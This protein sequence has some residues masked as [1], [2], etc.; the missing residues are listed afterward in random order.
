MDVNV[1]RIFVEKKEGFDIKAQTLLNELSES[2][3][4]EKLRRVR[5]I[6]RYDVENI[7]L[8]D[9]EK[10]KKTIF[11]DMCVDKVYDEDFH[12]SP[13]E[14]AFAI[15]YLPGQYDQRADFAM[16][17]IN[18]LTLS[19]KSIVK[20]AKL[21]ILEGDIT[22]EQFE[23]IKDYCINLLETREAS[24]KKPDT[25]LDE[26]AQIQ[27]VKTIKGFIGFLYDEMLSLYKNEG[28]A[29]SM[30][31]LLFC[32]DYFKN[33]EN[34][35]PTIT[36]L[37]VLDTY[38]S[39]HCR[40][41]TFLTKIDNLEIEN[42]KYTNI[43]QK[44]YDSY[45]ALR[46]KVYTKDSR[47]MTL[48]D[49]ATIN[50]KD[51]KKEGKLEDLDVSK[52]VNA[53]TIQLEAEVENE[54][55]EYLVSFKNETHNHPTEIEPFGGAAT[56]LGG[57]IRDPLSARAY[58]HQ[59]MRVSG[60]G[61][62]RTPISETL[63]GKLP[64][65]KITTVAAEGYSSYGNQIGLATGLV[66]EIYHEGYI[67]K[68]MEIGAVVG[69]T[70]KKNVCRKEP[71]KGD[72]VILLGG[73]T[74]RDGCGGATGSSKGHNEESI[75]ISSAEV[76]KGNP[77]T[78]RKIQRLF[79]DPSVS[80]L[81]K[82]CNDFGAG[83]VCVAIGEL[84]DG[85][86]I[87]LDKIPKKYQGLDGTELAISES[88]ERMAVVV[89]SKDESKFIELAF[90]ENLEATKVAVVTD[91]NR[92][93][94]RYKD[95]FIVDLDRAFLDT[96]GVSQHTKVLIKQPDS[97]GYF[98]KFEKY[99]EY[100]ISKKIWVECLQDL[101]VCSKKGLV[102]MF[103]ATIGAG[104]VNMPFGGKYQISPED[105]MIAKL[106]VLEGE[107][108][109]GTIMAYG[110]NPYISS[111]SPFHAGVY[112]LVEAVTKVVASGGDFRRIRLSLQEYF[113]KP[114]K[115]I[116]KWGSPFSA[117]L[118][119]SFAQKNLEIP[120]IGGKDSMSGNFKDMA[121]P[122]TI[123]SFALC[124]TDVSKTVYG[125]FKRSGSRVLLLQSKKDKE[126]LIDFEHLKVL[127]SN[128]NDCIKMGKVISARAVG[129]GGLIETISKMSFGNKM[130]FSF[131]D[132]IEGV[133][134][135]AH[136][137]IY[138]LYGSIV[139]EIDQEED[140][141]VLFPSLQPKTI[142]YTIDNKTIVFK[143]LKLDLDDLIDEWLKP[144]EAVFP[145]MAYEPEVDYPSCETIGRGGALVKPA[146]R[147]AKPKVFIPILPGTNCEYDTMRAFEKEGAEAEVFVVNNLSAESLKD[148]ILYMA[149]IIKKSQIIA[150][151]GGFSAGDEPDGAGKFIDTIF[152]NP[153][154]K[155][156][157]ME[158]IKSRDG[159]ILGICNGFQALV[160]LGLL[161][162]GE[163]LEKNENFPVLTFNNLGR[164]VS[165]MVRTK[166]ISDLSPWL[167]NFSVGDIHTIPV[168]H[169]EG[170]FV[171]DND[172]LDELIKNGQIAT[173][174]VDF[175]G[176][177]TNEST[178]NP[179]GSYL[180]IE[181]ITSKCG[182]IFGKMG[183]SERMGRNVCKNVPGN[184]NQDLF[185]SA[186]RYFK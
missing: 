23:R 153:Y 132:R 70:E 174:Y 118:G 50:M 81:I 184:K 100:R 123:V 45:L 41:T 67:A 173:Q 144:L 163:I 167:S 80:R 8:E 166:I 170:R 181:G 127:Y 156:E 172:L 20:T 79:R 122:P 78:Q 89:S 117:L 48:M 85:L 35:D 152:R 68:R 140:V 2:L 145:D 34:R 16:Q 142:G 175:E 87:D 116:T 90:N 169:G 168:S 18:A 39:D 96:N 161:P 75:E 27:D 165:R 54:K 15:E 104:T 178:F 183:H 37:K 139:V 148:S 158:L 121:V 11:S 51:M 9:F 43:V 110:F 61:D 179:N 112:S 102:E 26:D 113:E 93:K 171:A 55:K 125:N 25:L 63:K 130:G 3:R 98:E 180:A 185:S 141:E 38:W 143:E 99:K 120:A 155:E 138:P 21:F 128:I 36:E 109:T 119:A 92:L 69:A 182:K 114:G 57:A 162:F 19:D 47:D 10:A 17:C 31:D 134:V 74:G 150:I 135:T 146:I 46:K 59:A 176:I 52:E 4:L 32:Q 149:N 76:Q 131:Q 164:H 64:Q 133:K 60:S 103:D 129:C 159:L 77:P 44:A 72:V 95:A 5:L 147:V 151:P 186:V 97:S 84:S 24:F 14:I 101:N 12:I 29:M 126:H 30:E 71:V 124:P 1:R 66:S 49:L 107:T 91:D 53:C 88:Q 73:R 40:H 157:V 22:I 106:P 136:D 65:R 58:V 6:N 82:R 42:G 115:N 83:G 154:I 86:L 177:P 105:T 13:E 137:F 56:C 111:W 62:P 33:S 108:K 7:S 94:M 160:R 28:F